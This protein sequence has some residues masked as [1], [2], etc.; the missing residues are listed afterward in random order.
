M[1]V[2]ILTPEFPPQRGGIGTHCY[3]MARHW[4]ARVEV[5]VLAPAASGLRP[6]DAATFRIV[7]VP[8]GT[9]LA[10]QR[11]LAGQL[12]RLLRNHQI[13]VVYSAHWRS[14]GVALRLASLVS[15][16]RP[17]YVQA[18]HGSEVL[19]LLVGNAGPGGV[20]RPLFR[21]VTGAAEVLVALG[22]HQAQLLSRLGVPSGRIAVSPEGVDAARFERVDDATLTAMRARYGLAGRRVLLT[23][24]R[25][26]ERKGHDTVLRALPAILDR[27][28]ETVYLIVGSGPREPVLRSLARDLGVEDR[29]VFCGVVPDEELA[30][31]YWA[32]DVFVMPGR[33]VHGD[34]EGFGI[35]FMEAAAC[36]RPCIG[37]RSGGAAE[38]IAEGQSG[39]LVD[40]WSPEQLADTAIAL[41][42][43]A[44]LSARMGARARER[45]RAEFGNEQIANDL[46]D[47]AI[48]GTG[49]AAPPRGTR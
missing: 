44:T 45:A 30:A 3:E 46:L 12:R 15:A 20:Q 10:R 4:A 28:P 37:G 6:P 13:D 42:E 22:G 23:V 38:A 21:W 2:A 32:C 9:L 18:V 14:C 19:A 27:V 1:H 39:F 24:G 7:E 31:H 25:L 48:A 17:R 49:P 34:V 5:T 8:G 16:S 43:D 47:V 29:V 36:G 40:P 26:V 35:A 41:L 11:A 33:E